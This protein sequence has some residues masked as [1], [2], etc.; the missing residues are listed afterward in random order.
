MRFLD[1][2]V[3]DG[4][5]EGLSIRSS[6]LSGSPKREHHAEN[7]NRSRIPVAIIKP[8]IGAQSLWLPAGGGPRSGSTS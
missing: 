4:F 2:G 5:V 7:C 1:A 3:A 6:A 8:S